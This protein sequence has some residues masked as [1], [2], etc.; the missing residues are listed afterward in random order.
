MAQDVL[1]DRGIPRSGCARRERRYSLLF[2]SEFF[3]F[4]KNAAQAIGAGAGPAASDEECGRLDSSGDAIRRHAGA[5]LLSPHR[6]GG[7]TDP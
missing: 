1:R 5:D 7:T 6:L 3:L 4:S 2:R